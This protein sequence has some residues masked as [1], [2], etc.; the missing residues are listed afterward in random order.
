[1]A[2]PRVSARLLLS[3]V[4]V[5]AG[6]SAC[7][8][9]KD[10]RGYVPDE[11][12]VASIKIGEDTKQSV[13]DKLGTPSSTAAFG[14]PTWYYISSEQEQ[15]A[16]F[17][18]DVTKREILAVQFGDNGKVSE[19]RNY[20]IEDGQ[21]VALVDRETPSRGKELSFLQQIFGNIGGPSTSASPSG[22]GRPGGGQ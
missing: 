19:V 14:D 13:Q 22:P 4:L 15:Y 2:S 18:P 8:P 7:A 21:V 1:M 12:K 16:F 11:E 9:I 3:S 6:L 17:T 5:L 10:V 20:G